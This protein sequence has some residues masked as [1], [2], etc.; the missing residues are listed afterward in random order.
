M[1][2]F[3][4]LLNDASGSP[5]VLHS[6]V[7]ALTVAGMQGRLFI[8]SDGDGPLSSCGIPITRYWY[9]RTRHRLLTLF[10]YL[11][12]QIALL[13]KLLADRRIDARAVVYVNTLLPFGAA[14][15]GWL[16]RRRVIYHVHEVSLTP[17]PLR[18]LLVGVARMTS[19]CNIY[20]S[21]AHSRAL[22]IKGVRSVR[23][24]NALDDAFVTKALATGYSHRRNGC[25]KI[26][27]VAS[28]RDYKGAPE[29]FALAARFSAI[30]DIRFDLVVNDEQEEIRRYLSGKSVPHNV[31]VH[32]RVMDTSCF[33]ADASL[34]LNLS[35][36]DAWVETFGLTILEAMAYGVPVIVPP[37]GGPAELVREG[38]H[39]YLVDSRN[40]E[41]LYDTV[42]TL[43][44]SPALCE[45]LSRA[46]RMRSSDFS[47]AR[48][49][50]GLVTLM[51]G[52]AVNANEY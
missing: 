11:F 1:I 16:T 30:A 31:V 17:A 34:L 20:V 42:R 2:V 15:Y 49:R 41:K 38:R 52:Y 14:L 8:G 24:Y 29:F 4:H 37:A 40:A 7:K 18:W 33:Y 12:S 10:T 39:G 13:S 9:C 5:R 48:F 47:A 43:Y 6:A 51:S 45:A 32:A 3:A 21:D 36:V 35:R 46:C 22:P 27:M 23:L 50:E 19:S 44:D 26:L 28:L 25:F